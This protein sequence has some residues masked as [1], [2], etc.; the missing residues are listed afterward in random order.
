M[1]LKPI[2]LVEDNMED[3]EF[4]VKAL[5]IVGLNHP[6][7][8][9]DNAI[10][11]LKFLK[12]TGNDPLVIISDIA[13]PVM[14]GIEFRREILADP[15][16]I[17]KEIPF[18][19]LSTLAPAHYAKLIDKLEVQGHFKKPSDFKDML[20]ITRSIIDSFTQVS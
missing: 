19:F 1:S 10:E 7:K 6:I 11:A 13:M 2:V 18:V 20:H 4:L 8:C 3:C 15:I 9:F 14:N 16:L 12:A 5:T 17:K